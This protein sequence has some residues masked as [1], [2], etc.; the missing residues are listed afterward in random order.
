M[1]T[2]CSCQ[3]DIEKLTQKLKTKIWHYWGQITAWVSSGD[4][5]KDGTL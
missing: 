2:N 3:I 5:T 1:S 4:E